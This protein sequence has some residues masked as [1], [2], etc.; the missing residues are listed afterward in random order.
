MGGGFARRQF[1]PVILNRKLVFLRH[2]QVG[3]QAGI[4]TLYQSRQGLDGKQAT[5][6]QG[7]THTHTHPHTDNHNKTIHRTTTDKQHQQH[8]RNNNT[9]TRTH[10]QH[11]RHKQTRIEAERHEYVHTPPVLERDCDREV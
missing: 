11:K 1:R 9:Q 4:R 5:I 8:H 7:H 6:N 3:L 10:K 2:C